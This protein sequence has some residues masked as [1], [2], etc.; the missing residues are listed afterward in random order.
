MPFTVKNGSIAAGSVA[1]ILV[2]IAIATATPLSWLASGFVAGI[3]AKGMGRGA[4]SSLVSSLV[5]LFIMVTLAIFILPSGLSQLHS[6]IG[7]SFLYNF[8]AYS[9]NTMSIPTN[10]L[11][12]EIILDDV[13]LSIIGGLIGGSIFK[14]VLPR[15]DVPQAKK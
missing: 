3:A 1:G 15:E 2:M 5:T 11:I 10:K 7:N 9:L 13:L 14:S 6:T 8:I 4:S 12:K